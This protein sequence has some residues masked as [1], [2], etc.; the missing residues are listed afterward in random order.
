[1]ISKYPQM[2]LRDV[3]MTVSPLRLQHRDWNLKQTYKLWA[4]H[5][6]LA[7]GREGECKSSLARFLC[8]EAPDTALEA[9]ITIAGRDIQK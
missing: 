6:S 3:R 7:D 9:G 4:F 8:G 1:M 2:I 5:V